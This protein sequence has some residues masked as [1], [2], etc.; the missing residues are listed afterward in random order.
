MIYLDNNS[1]TPLSA[2][3]KEAI[4]STD[5]VAAHASPIHFAGRAAQQLLEDARAKVAL[6]LGPDAAKGDI[7]FTSGIY[8]NALT[9]VSSTVRALAEKGVLCCVA[10]HASI[11]SLKPV[12]EHFGGWMRFYP[13]TANGAIDLDEFKKYVERFTGLFFV[14]LVNS[15]TGVINP[16]A[17]IAEHV[18][19]LSPAIVYVDATQAVGRLDLGGIHDS[20]DVIS[21][22]AHT[23]HGPPCGILWI[24]EGVPL[25]PLFAGGQQQFQA[26]AAELLLLNITGAAAAAQEAATLLDTRYAAML[27]LQQELEGYLEAAG[28]TINSKSLPRVCN[29][30]SCHVGVDAEA[31][32]ELLSRLDIAVS[33]KSSFIAG[34]SHASHVMQAMGQENFWANVRFSTSAYNTAAEIKTAGEATTACIESL[35][36]LNVKL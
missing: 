16:V 36:K 2:A 13:I 4:A 17:A 30:T 14:S 1:G 32:V 29:T 12:C 21:F 9:F 5:P 3:A 31:V 35:R 23:F 33:C 10:D 18:K 24:R 22:S 15:E 19:A 11:V 20:I 34:T 27:P 7:V 8:E 25:M 28:F 26:R 6:L